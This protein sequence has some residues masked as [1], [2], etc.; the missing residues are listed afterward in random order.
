MQQT[1]KPVVLLILDGWGISDISKGNAITMAKTPVIDRLWNAYPHTQLRASGDSVGLPKDED[2]NTETGHLNIGAGSIVYQDLPRINQA[3]ADGTFASNSHF[4]E[5]IDHVRQHDSTLHLLGLIGSG[6]VHSNIEHLYALLALATNQKISKLVLHLITDGRDSPPT[7]GIN[8]IQQVQ[9]KLQELNNGV[10]G[11]IIGRYYAMD[12]D[13]RWER[14]ELAYR[15][16]TEGMGTVTA[17]PN[18]AILA[19][20]EKNITDEFIEPIIVPDANGTI[21]TVKEHDAVIFYNF[22]IDRPRQLTRAFVMPNFD[23]LSTEKEGF[24]PHAIDYHQSHVPKSTTKQKLFERGDPIADLYFV[25]MT[26]Y[27][28]FIPAHPAFP[29]ELVSMP[30]SRVVAEHGLRQLK[31]SETE[32]ERFVTYYFNGQREDPFVGEDWIIIPSP[33]I[34]TYDQ[35]PEMSSSELTETLI[36]RIFTNLYDLIIVNFAHPD[37]VAHTGNLEATIKACEATDALV[38]RITDAVTSLGG[39]TIITADHGNAEEL[40]NHETGQ[41]DTEHS[42]SPVP[43]ILIGK[44]YQQ[45]SA[46]LPIGILGDIA[47]TILKIMGLPIPSTMTGRPLL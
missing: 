41:V 15:A 16:L 4:L 28:K 47:P 31:M 33:D 17:D 29:P 30:L 23:T 26:E 20:Y 3:I 13:K 38:T 25:T 39:V 24:D 27:E 19:S 7:S 22:R 12:R 35:K 21:H 18:A 32:K 44:Q 34:A 10:I 37:M 46:Q 11:S 36:E 1:P 8:Y 5:A 6:G 45:Q 43:F 40:I 14:T 42:S 9:R 2:G